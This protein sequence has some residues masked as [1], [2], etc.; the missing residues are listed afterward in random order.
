MDP[1]DGQRRT[2]LQLQPADAAPRLAEAAGA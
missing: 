1:A 2:R